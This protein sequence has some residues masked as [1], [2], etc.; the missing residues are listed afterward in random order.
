[1]AM[2]SRASGSRAG[3]ILFCIENFEAFA[4]ASDGGL[5]HCFVQVCDILLCSKYV[6]HQLI[7]HEVGEENR[8]DFVLVWPLTDQLAFK[9][10]TKISCITVCTLYK[11]Q[12][13]NQRGLP[14]NTVTSNLSS[15]RYFVALGEL[16]DAIHTICSTYCTCRIRRQAQRQANSPKAAIQCVLYFVPKHNIVHNIRSV[17]SRLDNQL[18]LHFDLDLI[19]VQRVA[20]TFRSD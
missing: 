15:S 13:R 18:L 4:S 10:A 1:M 17:F 7:K 19:L 20:S 8:K 12:I 9:I 5:R 16:Q 2:I 14:K 6:I 11:R 3:I